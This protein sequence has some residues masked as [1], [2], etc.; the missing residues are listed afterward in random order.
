MA[1]ASLRTLVVMGVAGS[2]K[3][4]IGKLLAD[5][6]GALFEDGDDFHPPANKQ[7]MTAKIPL[8]DEDRGPWLEAM[9]ARIKEVRTEQPMYVL[10]C[11]ALKRSY[12][13]VL[14]GGDG[15]KILEFVYLK[16][17][18]E[19]I[20]ERMGAREGHFMPTALLDSQ[21]ATLEEP[22]NALVV[23]VDQTPQAI[24]EEIV[25]RLS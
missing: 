24:V 23:S 25:A 6:L 22:E 3:S 21:F 2:G 5:R 7:K 12:R 1:E 10:A 9:R 18:R 17:S 8:T 20:G 14:R 4:L 11:S 16:G 19:L 15:V 13:D